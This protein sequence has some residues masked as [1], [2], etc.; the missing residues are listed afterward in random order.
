MFNV[1]MKTFSCG[2]VTQS[3][4]ALEN[5]MVSSIGTRLSMTNM[6]PTLQIWVTRFASFIN[7][8]ACHFLFPLTIDWS[9]GYDMDHFS[10]FNANS[11]GKSILEGERS[12]CSIVEILAE[13]I[14]LHHL[15]DQEMKV[16]ALFDSMTL[17][18]VVFTK[19]IFIS[20]NYIPS[21]RI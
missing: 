18:L 13:L 15:F 17:V 5:T 20:L 6:T 4:F 21:H 9:L 12:L 7:V 14:G 10:S 11:R 2:W 19:A 1:K 3:R 8:L 16:V